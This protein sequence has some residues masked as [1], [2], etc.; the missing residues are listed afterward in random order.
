[1]PACIFTVLRNE[2]LELCMRAKK[3]KRKIDDNKKR[4][5]KLCMRVKEENR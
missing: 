3:K 2:V 1:M 5:N 4:P